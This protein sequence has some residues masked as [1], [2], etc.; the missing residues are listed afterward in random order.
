VAR[1]LAIE[2]PMATSLDESRSLPDA[3]ELRALHARLADR[4]RAAGEPGEFFAAFCR[5]IAAPLHADGAAVWLTSPGARPQLVAWHHL[6]PVDLAA[7]QPHVVEVLAQGVGKTA[8]GG[9]ATPRTPLLYPIRL[10]TTT[11][12]V[13]LVL[14]PADAARSA[15]VALQRALVPLCDFAGE[16]LFRRNQAATS[17]D[18]APRADADSPARRPRA[19]HPTRG[20]TAAASKTDVAAAPSADGKR[21][22]DAGR[23]ADIARLQELGRFAL[24]IHAGLDLRRTAA[25]IANETRRLADC[26]R[27]SVCVYR[28][29]RAEAAAFSGQDYFDRRSKLVKLVEALATAVAATGETIVWPRPDAALAPQIETALDAYL[30]ESQARALIVIPLGETGDAD[31]PS[32]AEVPA[33]DA[34]ARNVAGVLVA[35]QIAARHDAP[36]EGREKHETARRDPPHGRQPQPERPADFDAA[37]AEWRTVRSLAPHCAAALANAARH[38]AVPLRLLTR[39]AAAVGAAGA[40]RNLPKTTLIGGSILAVILALCLVPYRFEIEAR[41]TLQPIVRRDVFA[42]ADGTI[43]KIHIRTG[44]RVAANDVLFELRHNELDVA[45]ADLIKQINENEQELLNAQRAYNEGSRTLSAA[46][47]N[48]LLGQ[49]AVFEQRRDSLRRQAQ[50]FAER[51]EQLRVRS[52]IAGQVATWNVSEL[53]AERPVRRGQTLTSLVDPDGEWEVEIRVPEDRFGHLVES[54]DAGKEPLSVTFVLATDPGREYVGTVRKM[55]LAAEP[56][57][58]EGNVVRVVAAI[59]KKQLAQLQTGADVRVRIDCG[60]RSVGYVLLGDVWAFVQSRIL[61]K[62]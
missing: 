13:V 11:C 35:E 58:E 42:S 36:A 30:D 31:E 50:L 40:L 62:M 34:V 59:D 20:S 41:G 61:F 6:D 32:T 60:R 26:D 21:S 4:L 48:R 7:W 37:L 54:H 14:P 57:G 47:V 44:D 53:L 43:D 51:R 55:H 12:G 9:G 23:S 28:Y 56:H 18:A 38:D 17:K 27:T 33:I 22:A 39:S 24:A 52:P 5:D 29:R 1:L 49:V 45:E 46:E 15:V 8:T 2:I 3:D 10:G 16:Y 19:D 25:A